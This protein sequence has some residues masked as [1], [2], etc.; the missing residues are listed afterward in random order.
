MRM[1]LITKMMTIMVLM[2][3]KGLEVVVNKQMMATVRQP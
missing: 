3:K 2:L 1:Q